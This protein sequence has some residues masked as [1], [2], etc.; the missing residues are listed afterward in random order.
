MGVTKN[1]GYLRRIFY[2]SA[3]E[4][5]VMGPFLGEIPENLAGQSIFGLHIE[6]I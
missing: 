4:Q 3:N 6:V 5:E 2:F 1:E